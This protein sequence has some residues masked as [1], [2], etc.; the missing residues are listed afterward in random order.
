MIS[1]TK[2]IAHNIQIYVTLHLFAFYKTQ[3]GNAY[4][5][6][7]EYGYWLIDQGKVLIINRHNYM[8]KLP[9]EI[10]GGI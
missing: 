5:F 6:C 3:N 8:E 2:V 10:P 9:N 7:Y 4:F 1:G